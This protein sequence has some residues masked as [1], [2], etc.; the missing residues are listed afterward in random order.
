VINAGNKVASQVLLR[1]AGTDS[2]L[3]PGPQGDSLPLG[4]LQPGTSVD[5]T[6]QLVVSSAAEEG[7][8]MQPVTIR[9]LQEQEEKEIASS[10]TVDVSKAEK[11]VPLLLLESYDIGKDHLQPGDQFTLTMQLKNVGDGAASELLV[12]FGTVQTSGGSSGGDSDGGDGDSGGVDQS[13]TTPSTTFAPLGAGGTIYV[14][15]VEAGGDSITLEQEFIADGSI[16]SGIYSLPITL[17]YQKP[18]GTE[19]QDNLRASVVVIA[20]P[21]IQISLEGPLPETVNVGEPFPIPLTIQNTGAATVTLTTANTT[22]DNGDVVDGAEITVGAVAANE[23]TSI[24]A[25]VM[26]LEE[27]PVKVDIS[28]HYIND[29]NQEATIVKTYETQAILPPPMPE[30]SG[31]PPDMV[32]E[33]TEEE[34]DTSDKIGRFLLGLLGLGS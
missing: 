7:P 3:L 9:Y 13:S 21:T 14:G 20:P 1:F 10:I 6:L 23:D 4:D 31:P 17:R 28:L 24:S 11:P 19:A 27:G 34:D 12:T 30:E 15:N 29:L 26:A 22:A 32:E 5:I 8:R 2:I 33:P 18:D 16:D 25:M